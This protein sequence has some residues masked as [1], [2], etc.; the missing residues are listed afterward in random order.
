MHSSTGPGTPALWDTGLHTHG[1]S[2]TLQ[3]TS[4]GTFPYR[5]TLHAQTGTVFVASQNVP[6]TVALTSPT[7]GATFA[8]PWTGT[9]QA[10][11]ADSDG[12]VA[13][14][15]FFAG[16]TKLGTVSNPPPSLSLSVSN[17]AAGDYTLTAVATD[18]S[19]AANTSAGVLIHLLAPS[20]ILLNSP[21]WTAPASFQFS[22]T[23]TPGLS[24]VVQRSGSL[25]NF[26][27]LRTNVAES[28]PVVFVDTAASG[29]V[30]FY[31]VKLLPNP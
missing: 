20:P 31:S 21:H 10:S 28:T 14:V 19:G 6:P 5:C 29:P 2:F 15:D 18:N 3:F 9:I 8:A 30:N 4:G 26:V 12:T 27:P 22:Y 7:N 24:Y 1:F 23:A 17:L 13:K 16:A 25:P 11:A